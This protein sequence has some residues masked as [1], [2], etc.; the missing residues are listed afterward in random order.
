MKAKCGLG[1]IH[2]AEY[3]CAVTS[4]D[5]AFK[6][7]Q[8]FQCDIYVTSVSFITTDLFC[9]WLQCKQIT[10]TSHSDLNDPVSQVPL[11]RYDGSI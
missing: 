11:H 4:T 2:P 10:L 1:P 7:Q 3:V 5:M 6:M 8:Q 9:L